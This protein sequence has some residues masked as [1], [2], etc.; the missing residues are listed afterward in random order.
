MT[1]A[2][3]R[4]ARSALLPIA[5]I[6]LTVLAAGCS[7]E[8]QAPAPPPPPPG[9]TASFTVPPPVTV[10][11]PTPTVVIATEGP[12]RWTM[13]NLIG[14]NLQDA[15]NAIQELT[16]FEIPITASHDATGAGREQLLDRSWKVCSQNIPAGSEIS[17]TSRIDFGA[18]RTDE[19]C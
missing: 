4:P 12:Q 2:G 17:R 18:V 11:V 6:V 8:P 16:D 5:G 10:T 3:P 14:R 13:P 7:G 9:P 19:R 1:T 15:Q